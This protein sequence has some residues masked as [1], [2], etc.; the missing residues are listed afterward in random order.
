ME[1]WLKKI[2]GVTPVFE[3]AGSHF[4]LK[5]SLVIFLLWPSALGTLCNKFGQN[6]KSRFEVPTY[7]ERVARP[8]MFKFR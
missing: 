5:Q 7:Q 1:I 8:T 2:G 3:G 4:A 6:I